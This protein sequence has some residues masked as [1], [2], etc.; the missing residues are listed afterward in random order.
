MEKELR[1]NTEKY[2]H[3]IL[4]VK[5]IVEEYGEICGKKQMIDFRIKSAKSVA[6]K[7]KKKGYAVTFENAERYLNDLAGVRVICSCEEDVYELGEYLC[8]RKDMAIVGKK[9]YI[10][11]PKESGYKSLHLIAELKE[12]PSGQKIRAEIQIR[13]GVMHCW[14]ET[15]HRLCYKK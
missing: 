11:N 10:K 4:Q 5:E 1:I 3:G 7:L 9:D 13:T 14:A 12:Y 2:M 8:G 15:D 6:D